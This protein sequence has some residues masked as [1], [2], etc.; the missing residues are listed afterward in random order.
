MWPNSFTAKSWS[1][2][3][4]ITPCFFR[5]LG[6]LYG[7]CLSSLLLV[8]AL[9]SSFQAVMNHSLHLLA[10]SDGSSKFPPTFWLTSL[11]LL[12]HST[13][14]NNIPQSLYTSF[15]IRYQIRHYVL[16]PLFWLV[17]HQP[18]N[19]LINQTQNWFTYRRANWHMLKEYIN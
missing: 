3:H 8:F 16:F 19:I 15:N 5:N 18:I 9:I 13:H 1:F 10:I 14:S 2:P 12:S 17:C 7:R 11:N 6:H 4:L